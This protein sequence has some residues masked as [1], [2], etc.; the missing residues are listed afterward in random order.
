MVAGRCLG[1]WPAQCTI[2]FSMKK[3][4]SVNVGPPIYLVTQVLDRILK[5]DNELTN[6]EVRCTVPHTVTG[7]IH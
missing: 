3:A 5:R 1:R 2:I 6:R 4:N 7:R